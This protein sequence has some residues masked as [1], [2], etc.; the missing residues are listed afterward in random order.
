MDTKEALI[1]LRL[2][3]PD[4]TDRDVRDRTPITGTIGATGRYIDDPTSPTGK[5]I[6]WTVTTS[7]ADRASHNGIIV[8]L[9]KDQRID[10]LYELIDEEGLKDTGLGPIKQTTPQHNGE[11]AHRNQSGKST[12][13]E[14]EARQDGG[15]TTL[16]KGTSPDKI[17]HTFVTPVLEEK[18]AYYLKVRGEIY[19]RNIGGNAQSQ[20]GTHKPQISKDGVPSETQEAVVEVPGLKRTVRL[21]KRWTNVW[22]GEQKPDIRLQLSR[23][24]QTGGAMEIVAEKIV[25]G[26]TADSARITFENQD[27]IAGGTPYAS[28]DENGFPYTYSVSEIPVEGYEAPV[29]ARLN[30]E[31]TSWLIQNNKL[32]SKDP[33]GWTPEYTR[34]GE[35]TYP[36]DYRQDGPDIRNYK[37]PLDE[38]PLDKEHKPSGK[39]QGEPYKVNYEDTKLGKSGQQTA[40][41]GKFDMLLTAEGRSKF[42]SGNVDV[43]FVLDN[44]NSMQKKWDAPEGKVGKVRSMNQI[45]RELTEEILYPRNP[46]GTLDRTRTTGN[47]VG[48]TNFGVETLAYSNR[49]NVIGAGRRYTYPTDGP[50]TST[51]YDL[52]GSGENAKP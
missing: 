18:D 37:T 35:G 36:K 9:K 3:Y 4:Y 43:V 6:E 48:I 24:P 33:T 8:D 38:T 1:E 13:Y 11:I 14:A 31:G 19:H 44:S 47:R 21:E 45:V 7:H 27:W 39:D 29:V 42:G 41:P 30:L 40:R 12:Y 10:T 17:T 25:P 5:A 2:D 49:A 20:R 50:N 32:E 34:D 26:S 23:R 15:R 46:D 52:I 28:F 22:D 51:T 16:D